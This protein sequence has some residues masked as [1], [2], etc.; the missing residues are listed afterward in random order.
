VALSRPSPLGSASRIRSTV[1]SAVSADVSMVRVFR[2]P[3]SNRGKDASR[4]AA[5][6]STSL[7][8]ARRSGTT[9]LLANSSAV[10]VSRTT[11]IAADRRSVAA[12]M[13]LAIS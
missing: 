2:L 5:S 3:L 11:R 13:S 8:R 6:A 1:A 7:K 12:K 10:Q 9:T 4:R